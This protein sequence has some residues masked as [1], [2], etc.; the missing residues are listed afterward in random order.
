MFVNDGAFACLIFIEHSNLNYLNQAIP[1]IM[2]SVAEERSTGSDI[3]N[4]RVLGAQGVDVPLSQIGVL[5]GEWD[6]SRVARRNQQRALTVEFKHEVLKAPELLAAVI[7]E[8]EALGL[9]AEYRWEVGGEIES[10][11]TGPKSIV[12]WLLKVFNSANG[13]WIICTTNIR[14]YWPV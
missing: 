1:I 4:V 2:Q 7:P 3:Y 10:T 8:I 5:R 13:K 12:A 6:F 14:S 11:R 9:T